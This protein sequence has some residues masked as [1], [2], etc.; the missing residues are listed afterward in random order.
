MFK[1]TIKPTGCRK[2]NGFT[3]TELLIALVVAGILAAIAIP[4]YSSFVAGQRIKTVSFDLMSMLTLA[5]SEAIK[6]GARITVTPSTGNW[7][8]G[9]TITTASGDIL[10]RQNSLTGVT[11]TCMQGTPPA[12]AACN[13]ISFNASGR[14]ENSQ[15]LQINGTGTDARCIGIDLSGRPIS[16]KGNCQ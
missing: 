13:N 14:S 10:N 8:Q 6:R 2:K 5:R 3:L 1:S 11:V 7:S 16:M 9:W 12:T 4:S 15:R